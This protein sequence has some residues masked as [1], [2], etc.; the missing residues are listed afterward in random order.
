MGPAVTLS[1]GITVEP[2]ATLAL[3]GNGT[4]YTGPITLDNNTT[5]SMAT[6][7]A[8]TFP[9]NAITIA[10]GATATFTS[11][12]TGNALEGT[13]LSAGPPA[14]TSSTVQCPPCHH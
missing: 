10:N 8:A 6:S 13:H 1:G 7:S 4:A 14:P 12:S 9:V 2:N 3:T 11:G 5:F